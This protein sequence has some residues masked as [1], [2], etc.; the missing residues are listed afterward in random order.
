MGG[1]SESMVTYD[2]DKAIE[3]A[4]IVMAR[5]K[6]KMSSADVDLFRYIFELT[7]NERIRKGF[8]S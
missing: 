7:M 3:T 1:G 8:K 5:R 6:I 4:A 2:V